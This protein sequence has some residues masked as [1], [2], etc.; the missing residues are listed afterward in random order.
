MRWIKLYDSILSW[1]WSDNPNMVAL[2]VHLLFKANYKDERWHGIVVK[3]GQLVAGRK[4]LSELTGISERGVRTC[5]ERLKETGEIS[6]KTTNRYSLI[7][8]CKYDL[9]QGKIVDERPTNDQQTT[10]K[11]PANDHTYRIKEEK[12]SSV[13]DN[14]H[15]HTHAYERVYNLFFE[16]QIAAEALCKNEGID[17]ETCKALG[18][19]VLNDWE[20]TGESHLTETDARRHFLR[21]LRIKISRY[22]NDKK[23]DSDKRRGT[24]TSATRPED[25][26]EAF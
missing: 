13:V 19:E 6:I 8:I 20:L 22:K 5:L 17:L 25:Y 2:W 18:R 16:G 26:E 15:T 24:D 3:R 23:T 9:Y 7:T 14:A 11:R 21:H 4:A 1:E 10:N 12:I